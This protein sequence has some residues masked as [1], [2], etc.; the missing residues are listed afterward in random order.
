MAKEKKPKKAKVVKTRNNASMTES[1]FFGWLRSRLRR[2]SIYW[3][4]IQQ[5]KQEAKVPYI[6]PNN[7]RKFSYVCGHC[8]NTVSDKECAVHHKIP[9]GTLKSF[10]DLPGFCERL[11]VEKEFLILL[12]DTCHTKEHEKEKLN[13]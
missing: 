7:R 5:V 2:L 12:C 6:G 10:N 1:A 3:K 4:P 11:F 9:A 8:G 13:K